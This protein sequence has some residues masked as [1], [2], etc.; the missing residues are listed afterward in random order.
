MTFWNQKACHFRDDSQVRFIVI[1]LYIKEPPDIF[2]DSSTNWACKMHDLWP[3]VLSTDVFG[4]KCCLR[5]YSAIA[6]SAIRGESLVCIKKSLQLAAKYVHVYSV[7]KNAFI[8]SV[9]RMHDLQGHWFW[10]KRIEPLGNT[11][12][13]IIFRSR[14]SSKWR[15][16]AMGEW[17]SVT[18]SFALVD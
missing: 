6:R 11:Y 17:T 4:R 3:K 16:R 12:I 1:I 14:L 9:Q 10:K 7:I 15:I 2:S 13:H 5:M 18:L 8:Q